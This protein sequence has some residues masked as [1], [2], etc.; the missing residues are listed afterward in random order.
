VARLYA[1]P[2]FL[3]K[4]RATFEGDFTL[5]FYFAPPILPQSGA[6]TPRKRRFGAWAL[7]ALRFL[8]AMR[9]L[10]G[11]WL[12]P[13]RFSPD[14]KLERDLLRDYE[15][16][17]SDVAARLSAA[18]LDMAVELAALPQRMRGYGHVKARYVAQAR[19]RQAVLKKSF[20]AAEAKKQ[21]RLTAPRD[22]VGEASADAS[23]P[24]GS[25]GVITGTEGRK[26]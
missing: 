21:P 25:S 13:F 20:D 26:S 8:S 17:M 2:E 10:R 6:R 19:K 24:N 12:D 16:M 1:R 11:S 4:L 7:P 23:Q 22:E 9:F 18:N 3:Q 5:S 14:R 15:Q